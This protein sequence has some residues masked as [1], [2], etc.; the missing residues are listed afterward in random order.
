MIN[1][2]EAITILNDYL[3]NVEPQFQEIIKKIFNIIQLHKINY[4]V[5]I[6]WK[7]L[8]FAFNNDFNHWICAIGTTKK[9][10]N[11]VFHFGGLLEDK[12][13][14]FKTGTSKFLRRIEHKTLSDINEKQVNVLLNQAIDKLQYFKDNWKDINKNN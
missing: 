8:T 7:Q 13:N 14:L 10:V 9:S 4:D 6:K 12:N 11:L 1:D 3:R 2:K 5:A